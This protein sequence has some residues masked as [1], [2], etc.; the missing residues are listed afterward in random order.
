MLYVISTRGR[1]PPPV[2]PTMVASTELARWG[3]PWLSSIYC[4][5]VSHV[6]YVLVYI[7]GLH[8]HVYMGL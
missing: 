4:L 5:L 3:A 6:F 7:W 2:T 8:L 1:V